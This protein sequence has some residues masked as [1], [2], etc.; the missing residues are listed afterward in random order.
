[1]KL[2]QENAVTLQPT[3]EPTQPASRIKLSDIATPE[4]IRAME[5]AVRVALEIREGR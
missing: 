3:P 2:S 4:Q 5:R 1:M